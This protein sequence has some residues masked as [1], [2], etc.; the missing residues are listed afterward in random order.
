MEKTKFERD[1]EAHC[2]ECLS[3]GM[4]ICNCP[5]H[6]IN[7]VEFSRCGI[8]GIAYCSEEGQTDMHICG[9]CE[10]RVDQNVDANNEIINPNLF[11]N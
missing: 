6:F 4:D 5:G 10:A 3:Q 2:A 8:C 9:E 7:E 11:N 1:C